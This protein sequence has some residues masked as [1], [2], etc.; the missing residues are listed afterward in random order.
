MGKIMKSYEYLVNDNIG[1]TLG[2]F[3]FIEHAIIFVKALF[4]TYYNEENFKVTIVR[5]EKE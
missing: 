2:V 5:Q 3:D 1:Q 4:E